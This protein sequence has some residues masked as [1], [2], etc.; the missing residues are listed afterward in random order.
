MWRMVPFIFLTPFESGVAGFGR[1]EASVQ[2]SCS[3]RVDAVTATAGA[4]ARRTSNAP[5]V[6]GMLDPELFHT[7]I[8][9]CM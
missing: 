5:P 3:L 7:Y 9:I 8:K 4:A 2:G 1:W 6:Q